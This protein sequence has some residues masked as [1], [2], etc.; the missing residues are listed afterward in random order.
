MYEH[1][2]RQ[3]EQ[4]VEKNNKV[5]VIRVEGSKVIVKKILEEQ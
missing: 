2:I 4:I 1:N 3:I 5:E